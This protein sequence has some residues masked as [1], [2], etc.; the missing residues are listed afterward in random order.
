M[1]RYAL[2]TGAS[3]G[4]GRALTIRLRVAGWQLALVSRHAETLDFAKAFEPLVI[5]ADTSQAGGASMALNLAIEK[6][7]TPP[8]ALAHCAGSTLITPMHKTTDE[9]FRQIMAANLD[10]AFFTL[11]AYVDACLQHQT[12]GA[13]ALVSS[14]VARIGVANHE[15]IAASKGALEAL[16]RSAAATYSAKGIRINAIAPGLMRSPLT[17]CLFVGNEIGLGLFVAL[18]ASPELLD[19]LALRLP[20][21]RQAMA[22][23]PERGEGARLPSGQTLIDD[24]RCQQRQGQ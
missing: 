10:S 18:R 6:F 20:I 5:E 2:I 7:G 14:V 22:L 21:I 9:Q 3:G 17:E 12:G 8:A 15:A 11:R 13:V 23:Q 16:G 4:L 1:S 19:G 24:R